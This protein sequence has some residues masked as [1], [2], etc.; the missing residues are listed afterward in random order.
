MMFTEFSDGAQGTQV[1]GPI[2][3]PDLA[4]AIPSKKAPSMAPAMA[5]APSMASAAAGANPL[6]S[7]LADVRS[8][9]SFFRMP[10][11]VSLVAGTSNMQPY[12]TP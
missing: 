3:A 11:P 6:I 4:P 1:E 10:V 7:L 5:P 12:Q 2:P 8:P 9:F